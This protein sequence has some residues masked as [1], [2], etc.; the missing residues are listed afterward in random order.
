MKLFRVAPLV[1]VAGA[2][3]QPFVLA[4]QTNTAASAFDR[5]AERYPV[6]VVRYDW[7]DAKRN[8]KVPVKIYYPKT[9]EGTFP[10]IVF[11]HGLG[12]S[13]EGYEYL[14]RHWAGCGYV[15]VHVQHLGSDNAVWQDSPRAEIMEN[16]RRAAMNIANITNRPADITF[17]I[18]QLEQINKSDSVLKGR[19][20]LSRIG[21]AGH[22]F[23][24]FT[25]LAVAGETFITPG[26]RHLSAIDPRIKA[27]I[28]MSSPVPEN[29]AHFDEGFASIKVPCLHMTGT[30]DSSP[31]GNT[32]PKERRIPF[33]HSRN[34][35]QFLIT[36]DGGDHMIFSGRGRLMPNDKDEEFQKLICIGSTAFWDAYLAGDASAKAWFTG[37]GFARALGS[38]GTFEMKLCLENGS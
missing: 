34:S 38:E 24:A 27:A 37:G 19:L 3:L 11:S 14:G 5:S 2:C 21:M 13:R 28:P 6:E 17:V 18:D 26:G 15:S 10:V 22:S 20:D 32:T 4:A 30:L 36:F 31:I 33:D 8:R 9:A 1:L 7:I 25:T 23:G 29:A 35:D 12:G 16:M